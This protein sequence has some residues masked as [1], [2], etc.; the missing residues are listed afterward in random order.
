MADE[1]QFR[2][3]DVINIQFTFREI[4]FDTKK[5]NT[6]QGIDDFLPDNMKND[7]YKNSAIFDNTISENVK[8]LKVGVVYGILDNIQVELPYTNFN[9]LD[10]VKKQNIL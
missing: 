10:I 5:F 9:F 8:P 4:L 6:L 2:Y 1:Y 3:K 7:T